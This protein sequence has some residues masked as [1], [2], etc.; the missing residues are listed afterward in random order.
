VERLRVVLGAV[1]VIAVLAAVIWWADAVH[2]WP[3]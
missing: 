3:Q 1:A 2:G